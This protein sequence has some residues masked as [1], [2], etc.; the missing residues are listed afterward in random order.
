MIMTKYTIDFN[1]R[2]LIIN[3]EIDQFAEKMT[4]FLEKKTAAAEEAA[5]HLQKPLQELRAK[6]ET[7]QKMA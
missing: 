4:P 2:K 1:D 3:E 5:R 6:R 7:A